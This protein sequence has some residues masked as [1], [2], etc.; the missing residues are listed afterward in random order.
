MEDKDYPCGNCNFVFMLKKHFLTANIALVF[1]VFPNS[2]T[3]KNIVDLD[4]IPSS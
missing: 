2:L 4:L 1:A 3:E